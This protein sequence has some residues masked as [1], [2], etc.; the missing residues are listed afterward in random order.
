MIGKFL[1]GQVS[2]VISLLI[3][4]TNTLFWATFL[5]LVAILKL[6]IPIESWRKFCNRIL[7][8]IATNWISINNVGLGF[9]HEISW[10]VEGFDELEK[11]EWYLIL[12]NHQTW[13]DIPVL[14]KVANRKIPFI[15][16][17]IKKELLWVPVLGI[18]WWA[19]DYPIVS[20]YSSEFFKKNP[21]LKG[22]DLEKTRKACEKFKTI[23]VSVMNFV[24]GTRFT[25]EKHERQESP[26]A[27]LLKP[28]AGGTAYALSVLRDH[29][30]AILN[31]TIVYPEGAGTMWEFLCGKITRIIVK[32]EKLP[33]SEEVLGDYFED[34]KFKDEF[35]EWLNEIWLAKDEQIRTILAEQRNLS[36]S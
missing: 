3:M 34:M 9:V 12:S 28:K 10:K 23:P 14:Q 35:Q 22:K 27:H 19:L 25:P 24:E 17:F 2:G 31:V 8:G 18:A 16:F 6:I 29:F 36:S 21:H 32:A 30:T 13:V 7:D 20:R 26:F 15:K 1:P 5:Y 33:I 11:N 4:V